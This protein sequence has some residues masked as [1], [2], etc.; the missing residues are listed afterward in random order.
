M[1]LTLGQNSDKP[2]KRGNI[3]Y[4]VAEEMRGKLYPP[5]WSDYGPYRRTWMK[6]KNSNCGP[7]SFGFHV[8]LTKK[9]ALR[10]MGGPIIQVKVRG[11]LASGSTGVQ[12]PSETWREMRLV[13]VYPKKSAKK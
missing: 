7:K 9:A 10:Y 2:L 12:L 5:F 4:K 8:F 11:F 6:A 1:C 13:K 3:R